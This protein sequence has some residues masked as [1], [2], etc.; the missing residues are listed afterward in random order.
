M[1]VP[2][3]T[4][5]RIKVKEVQNKTAGGIYLPDKARNFAEISCNVGEVTG[6]GSCAF[7]GTA[8]NPTDEP[9]FKVGD[10]VFFIKHAGFQVAKKDKDLIERIIDWRDVKALVE[11]SDDLGL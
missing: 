10:H 6:I 9:L 11:D 1:S 4:Q 3:G 5:V 2:L 7:K 8:E